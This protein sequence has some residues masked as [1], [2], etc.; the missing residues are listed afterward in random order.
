MIQKGTLSLTMSHGTLSEIPCFS[1]L[2]FNVFAYIYTGAAVIL[3]NGCLPLVVF[4]FFEL[5]G[6]S[7]H[8]YLA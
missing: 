5:L 3:C 1:D 2:A 4:D 8:L 7:E 6:D